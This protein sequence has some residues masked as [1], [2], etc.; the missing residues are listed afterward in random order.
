MKRQTK[1]SILETL[2]QIEKFNKVEIMLVKPQHETKLFE[3]PGFKSV[4]QYSVSNIPH[5]LEIGMT[6]GVRYFIDQLPKWKP[7]NVEMK[8][9]KVGHEIQNR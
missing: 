7:R 4:C 9:T 3:L 8:I 5:R 2:K 6:A 1:A